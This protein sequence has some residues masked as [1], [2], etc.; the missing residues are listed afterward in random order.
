[1]EDEICLLDI[2]PKSLDLL[3]IDK[4]L[5][6]SVDTL[7]AGLSSVS[8]ELSNT[9]STPYEVAIEMSFLSE[10]IESTLRTVI[11]H[12]G[13]QA[14]PSELDSSQTLVSE[15]TRPLLHLRK[16]DDVDALIG[17]F[18]RYD[19]YFATR[20]VL[21]LSPEQS[22]VQILRTAHLVLTDVPNCMIDVN[23]VRCIVDALT[24]ILAEELSGRVDRPSRNANSSSIALQRETSDASILRRWKIG[25]HLFN[26]LII[27]ACR[28]LDAAART[29][30]IEEI[31]RHLERVSVIFRGTTATMWYAESFPRSKYVLLVRPSMVEASRPEYGFSGTDNLEYRFFKVSFNNLFARLEELFGP[32]RV[33]PE[34]LRSSAMDFVRT[35]QLDL[36]HH[37]LLAEKV[38][39]LGLSLKQAKH[40]EV[41]EDYVSQDDP[42]IDA[43]RRIGDTV[44]RLKDEFE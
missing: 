41:S 40:R 32:K 20:R 17:T 5:A 42:A 6:S 8:D 43:L 13:Q 33:W 39:N 4:V 34:P 44:R 10:L 15:I 36:E 23:E 38:V 25:H 21:R 14:T 27:C 30:E 12:F 9:V 1:M 28:E 35:R 29:D 2:A 7:V 18:I 3:P 37:T 19:R 26:Q 16:L 22:L 11:D 24:T 31:T